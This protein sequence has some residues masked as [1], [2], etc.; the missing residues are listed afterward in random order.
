M[1]K[2]GPA[3]AAELASR[4]T[5]R[6][7]LKHCARGQRHIFAASA[8]GAAA[9]GRLQ[10]TNSALLP[11]RPIE[12]RWPYW[13][14]LCIGIPA[15][16]QA[17][18]LTGCICSRRLVLRSRASAHQDHALRLPLAFVPV[19]LWTTLARLGVP[20]WLMQDSVR[21][22]CS[23][24]SRGCC[25]CSFEACAIVSARCISRHVVRYHSSKH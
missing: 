11:V 18:P 1:P 2:G 9:A 15:R 16:A 24:Y 14:L 17:E 6:S 10:P 23:D 7:I 12:R 3:R 21:S 25:S 13:G 22:K 8:P 5:S 4:S 19:R 20:T